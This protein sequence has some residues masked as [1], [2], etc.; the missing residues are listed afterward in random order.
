MED[1]AAGDEKYFRGSVG[2]SGDSISLVGRGDE[3]VARFRDEHKGD[4]R[5]IDGRGKLV[6]PGL[7]NT[8]NHVSMTLLRGA[9]DDLALMEWL[10]KH[11]WPFEAKLTP[12]DVMTG[13]RLGIAEMLLGGTTTFVD[14]YW[15]E[16][17]VAEAVKESGIRG[18]L[19]ATFTDFRFDDFKKDLAELVA[20]YGQG[21][22]PRISLMVAPHS[23][24]S[25]STENIL[26]G[27]EMA[28]RYGLPLNIHVSETEDE[29]R[30]IMERYGKT[31]IEYLDELGMLMPSTLVVH[32]VHV[33][34]NDI[35]IM[36][37][38]GVSA[39]H[40]PHSNMKLAS[41]VSPVAKMVEAGINVSVGT[42]GPSSNND[43]DMWEEM[44][45]ASFL[46]KLS[47]GNPT[48]LPAY[49]VLEMGTVNGARAI[50]MEDRIGRLR[51]GMLADVIVLDIEKPH[52]YPQYDIVANLVYCAK[53]SDVET[54]IVGG[55]IVVDKGETVYLDSVALCR[56]T[57]ARVED[58]LKR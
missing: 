18:V 36:R 57:Q 26:Y 43:L 5:E 17:A 55:D 4:Y 38:R 24:Y 15:Y 10:N 34:D 9:A 11:I 29:Q 1:A 2:I 40:N 51:E 54:V 47:T 6:M 23:A 3:G 39:A 25:I 20:A 14:M 28:E 42:D 50:G 22:H 52:M 8:H 49:R 53:A 32:A 35:A 45:T 7:V 21:Q 27:K 12:D 41:G 37:R 16:M 58:I 19:S 30:Q 31:P 13:A 46:H 56:E 33:S 48:V 44:R